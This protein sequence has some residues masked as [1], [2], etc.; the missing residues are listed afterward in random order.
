[1]LQDTEP[2]KI[3]PPDGSQDGPFFHPGASSSNGRPPTHH[4]SQIPLESSSK[5]PTD[6]ENF[7]K[8]H[9]TSSCVSGG[10][11]ASQQPVQA[12]LRVDYHDYKEKKD[13]ERSAPQTA[14]PRCV[15]NIFL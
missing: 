8:L 1:L 14:V 7:K 11:V 3:R 13:R 2:R 4:L 5:T 6:G 15:I 10:S 9:Q 12:P